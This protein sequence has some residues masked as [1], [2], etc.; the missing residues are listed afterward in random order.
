MSLGQSTRLLW[1]RLGHP[2]EAAAGPSMGH[3]SVVLT[4]VELAQNKV[5]IYQPPSPMFLPL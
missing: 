3:E 4:G 5:G 1:L 2:T